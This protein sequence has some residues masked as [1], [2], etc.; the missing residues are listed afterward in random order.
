MDFISA[1]RNGLREPHPLL[2]G[3]GPFEKEK[4]K[5]RFVQAGWRAPDLS[6]E[7]AK[8]GLAFPL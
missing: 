2:V 7:G 6:I 4:W 1:L 8:N 5:D 3:A